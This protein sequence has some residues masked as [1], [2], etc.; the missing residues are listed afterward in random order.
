MKNRSCLQMLL[1]TLPIVVTVSTFT[2]VYTQ[3]NS[4]DSRTLK[5]LYLNMPDQVRPSHSIGRDEVN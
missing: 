5:Y 4:T 1:S 2:S 3:S